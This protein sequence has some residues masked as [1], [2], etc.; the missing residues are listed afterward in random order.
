MII[1]CF[2]ILHVV[3]YFLGISDGLYFISTVQIIETSYNTLTREFY[4]EMYHIC[5]YNCS[6]GFNLC[7]YVVQCRKTISQH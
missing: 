7:L 5:C 2:R 1:L 4:T 3:L 6:C